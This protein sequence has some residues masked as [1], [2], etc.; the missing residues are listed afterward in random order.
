MTKRQ[1]PNFETKQKALRL[2]GVR[3][4]G[5]FGTA[6][7][8]PKTNKPYTNA[9]VARELNISKAAVFAWRKKSAEIMAL[10]N[11]S[12][13][14]RKMSR[15]STGQFPELEKALYE[16]IMERIV[17]MKG[18]SLFR[19]DVC[20]RIS[21]EL[22]DKLVESLSAR[23]ET[24]DMDSSTAIQ[25]KID[26]LKA[27]KASHGWVDNFMKRN[28]L[29]S[30][31]GLGQNGHFTEATVASARL[32]LQKQ[33]AVFPI[34]EISNT[35]EVALL[36]RSF[37]SR[38]I[39]SSNRAAT[40]G[41]VKD[42]LTA[43]L[44]VFADGRKAPLVVIGKS[45]TPRSFPRHFDPMRDLGIFY[46]SQC[47]AWNTKHLWAITMRGYDKIGEL[48]G[49]TLVNI[50]DKCSAHAIDYNVYH[51]VV[52]MFLPPNMTSCLQPVDASIGRS[53][54]CAFRRLLV[55]HILEYVDKLMLLPA[56][57]RGTFKI[58]QA[59]TTYD[60]VC[61]MAK[62]WNMVPQSV[63][64]NGWL[65]TGILAPFQQEK[66]KSIRDENITKVEP[67]FRPPR[68]SALSTEKA[69]FTLRA[70]N[71][72]MEGEAWLKTLDDA[73]VNSLI[74]P[75]ENCNRW[76]ED[77]M[78]EFIN[79]VDTLG[80]LEVIEGFS[81]L[82]M[83]A[84]LSEEDGLDCCQPVTEGNAVDVAVSAAIEAD[85]ETVP[86]LNISDTEP[87][88]EI[89]VEHRQPSIIKFQRAAEAF[90]QELK[91]MVAANHELL[92]GSRADL[93]GIIDLEIQNVMDYRKK[94]SRQSRISEFFVKS[95][96][97]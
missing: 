6:Q 86:A 57:E 24:A 59:V 54:K 97:E 18:E 41:R 8:D 47:N 77:N 64:I 46:Q 69:V 3:N 51:N 80:E 13:K 30:S 88:I 92:K 89:D 12:K 32:A 28:A 70:K 60:A 19:A 85:S 67:S 4:D 45:K 94:T 25:A 75:D 1:Q 15:M 42:R 27:F 96:E 61:M 81:E 63:V 33:L 84:F 91:I 74:D 65:Q 21:L 58:W 71:A 39:R 49:R 82:D 14:L 55:E 31:K 72:K 26:R 23:I 2:L 16:F 35:D 76:N 43:V 90:A 5:T 95:N 50:V 36:Y 48:E 79:D 56:E 10:S 66:L 7:T 93:A 44:T 53:F 78:R 38:A 37:P 9:A 87:D 52:S 17:Y 40:Y 29:H 62:A 34:Q 83:E 68:G 11:G 20:M 73:A 22:R